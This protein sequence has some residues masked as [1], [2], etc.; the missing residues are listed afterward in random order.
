MTVCVCVCRLTLILLVQCLSISHPN[1][2]HAFQFEFHPYIQYTYICIY[3]CTLFTCCLSFTLPHLHTLFLFHVLNFCTSI[4]MARLFVQYLLV[5]SRTKTHSHRTQ[6]TIQKYIQFLLTLCIIPAFVQHGEKANSFWFLICSFDHTSH[7]HIVHPHTPCGSLFHFSIIHWVS[8][9]HGMRNRFKRV[10]NTFITTFQIVRSIKSSWLRRPARI[11]QH[12][13]ASHNISMHL[14][15]D[16]R[17]YLSTS[18]TVRSWCMQYMRKIED[19]SSTR[20]VP[21]FLNKTCTKIGIQ[22]WFL[23]LSLY[24]YALWILSLFWLLKCTYEAHASA[25]KHFI[26]YTV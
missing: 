4:E 16:V 5:C 14:V 21:N 6:Y 26:P 20:C 22:N 18:Y 19:T 2:C 15:Y 24:L 3:M 7:T 9:S 23:S 13:V 12:R 25:L 1:P 17:K 11:A 8:E 10:G